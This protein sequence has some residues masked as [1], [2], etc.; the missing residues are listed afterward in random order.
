MLEI[1]RPYAGDPLPDLASYDAL[2][3]LGG[4]MGANDD[5]E[6]AW[7]TPLKGM[8][9][10]AAARG[11]PTLGAC[12]GHQ[13]AAV[14][15]GGSV[16]RNQRGQQLGLLEVGW[17]AAASADALVGG[18]ATPRRGIQWNNDVVT[19][20]PAGATLLA[21]TPAGEIQVARFAPT[22]WGVQLH[23]EADDAVV[24]AWADGDRAEHLE[25]GID[26]AGL[27]REIAAART[28]LDAAWRPLAQRFAELAGA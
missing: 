27:I 1:C 2:V 21:S 7:L 16:A 14:A 23:P 18:F 6:H 8:V 25:R 26:Q 28:E 20:L 24:R 22:V 13:L 19:Q 11:L 4:T 12:L 3:V 17:S 15:L 10:D 5:A 9:R